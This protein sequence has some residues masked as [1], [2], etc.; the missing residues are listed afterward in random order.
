VPHK[1]AVVAHLDDLTSTA[2]RLAAVNTILR[3]G[4]RLIGDNTDVAGFRSALEE[5]GV[6]VAHR[7]V[8]VLGAG[9]AARAVVAALLDD[10]ADV[11]I[12]NRTSVRAQALADELAPDGRVTVLTDEPALVSAV[13]SCALLVNTTSVGMDGG[14]SGNPLPD[15]VLPRQGVVVDLVYRPRRT[16]LLAAAQ[17]AGLTTLD[18]VPMLVHQGARALEAWTGVPAPVAVMRAAVEAAL[19]P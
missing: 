1:A 9:G 14:P 6:V 16:P 11:A 8:V 13:R 19:A 17:D 7:R 18:G 4:T 15:G 2:A 12:H 3:R 5:A 10:G